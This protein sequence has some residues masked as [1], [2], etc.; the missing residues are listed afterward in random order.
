MAGGF[1]PDRSRGLPH[2]RRFLPHCDRL[3]PPTSG[4][5]PA[6][7]AS[8]RIFPHKFLLGDGV[9]AFWSIWGS[10]GGKNQDGETRRAELSGK[11]CGLLQV[12]TR[13]FTKVRTDQGRGLASQAR[14]K[15]GAQKSCS[16]A[17]NVVAIVRIV[18]GGTFF[19]DNEARK[20]GKQERNFN[21]EPREICE[22]EILTH[23]PAPSHRS[24]RG[25]MFVGRAYPG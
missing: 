12:V 8:S 23:P 6:L 10:G 4:F 21:R 20:S 13:M 14:H 17:R 25:E 1:L 15:M 16:L 18:T 2:G 9:V 19:L 5:F 24:G 3:F 11:K 7:P 22:Q